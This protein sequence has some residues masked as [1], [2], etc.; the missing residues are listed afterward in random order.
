MKA[1]WLRPVL[2]AAVLSTACRQGAVHQG[3]SVRR[4]S[5]LDVALGVQ[6]YSL[7]VA[8]KRRQDVPA[9]PH[10]VIVLLHVRITNPADRQVWA[11]DCDA[12]A[13][14]DQN[15]FLYDFSFTPDIPAGAYIARTS[16]FQS[17][18]EAGAPTS[19]KEA[20]KTSRVTAECAAWDW[21]NDP[22]E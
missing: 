20:E 6:I 4:A 11:N 10:R 19:M 15:H 16:A 13:Y 21:G 22:P 9:D 14:D 8:P 18:V 3:V 1:P 7:E 12:R 5:V 17:V 2:M